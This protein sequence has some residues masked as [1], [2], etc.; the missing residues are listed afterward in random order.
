[1]QGDDEVTDRSSNV[2]ADRVPCAHCGQTGTCKNGPDGQSCEVCIRRNRPFWGIFGSRNQGA[3]VGIVCSVCRG[4]GTI[5]PLSV[6]LHKRI[7]PLLAMII[8]YV[9][10]YI[11]F[12]HA[13]EDKFDQ[14]LAFA[15]T[16]I[17]S[18]TGYYFGGLQRST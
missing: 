1:M 5:E 11:V 15:G 18:I 3:A 10:L 16:L 13:T 7:V 12:A 6:R 17:G 4:F 2:M 8:V 14:I 9:A